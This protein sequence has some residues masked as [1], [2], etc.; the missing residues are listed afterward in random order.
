MR[1]VESTIKVQ[2]QVL[3]GIEG[4]V[5]RRLRILTFLESVYA[6]VM[7]VCVRST[8][9]IFFSGVICGCVLVRDVVLPCRLMV[10]KR[11]CSFA[12]SV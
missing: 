12:G 11:L 1:R 4:C 6:L 7:L 10:S 9:M 2:W 3:V 5:Q 8:S